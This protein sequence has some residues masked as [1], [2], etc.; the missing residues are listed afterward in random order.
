MVDA[1]VQRSTTG[2]GQSSVAPEVQNENVITDIV[3]N[4]TENPVADT[5][6]AMVESVV[7]MYCRIFQC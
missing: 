5:D 7:R 4:H 1:H 2:K 3:L 6:T